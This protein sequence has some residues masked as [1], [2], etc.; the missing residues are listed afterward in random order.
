VRKRDNKLLY[1]GRHVYS[2]NLYLQI[3]FIFVFKSDFKTSTIHINGFVP[4]FASK[5]FPRL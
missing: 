5:V 2:L 4:N 3:T 1:V